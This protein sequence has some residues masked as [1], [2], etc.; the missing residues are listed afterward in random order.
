MPKPIALSTMWAQQDR[1]AGNLRAFAEVAR[2]AGYSHIEVS[3]ST[4]EEG[5]EQILRQD[6][7]PISSLHAPT[8]LARDAAGRPNTHLNLASADEE[9]RRA[10]VAAHLRT[11]GVAADWGIGYVVVHLGWAGNGPIAAETALRRLYNAGQT[12]GA[13][14]DA[15]RERARAERAAG[16]R[17]ALPAVRRSLDELVAHAGGRGVR[18]GLETRVGYHEL[19]S[20]D[21]AA[22][23]LA[24]QD[25]GVAGYWHDVG[26]AEVQHRLGLEERERWCAVLGERLIGCHLHDMHGITDHR[27]PGLGDVQWGY[28]ARGLAS[29]AVRTL[30]IDQRQPEPSLA[31]ALT[32]LRREGVLGDD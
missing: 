21:E 19:P 5:L 1:F 16:G 27:A 30:E 17:A 31:D 6:L 10:A 32:L 4:D 7:L 2:T 15:L 28:L 24:E 3:H 26:H 8:P 9:E 25:P 22:A 14:V 11:I 23:L 20:L 13:E 29:A 18:L 12:S